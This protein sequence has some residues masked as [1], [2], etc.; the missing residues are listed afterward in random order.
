MSSA[1]AAH[2]RSG[3]ASYS[4]ERRERV[5]VAG[6]HDV[7]ERR[8]VGLQR[9]RERAAVEFAEL[10]RAQIRT[11]AG[12]AAERADLV[13]PVSG[14][15][16]HRPHAELEQ[17]EARLDEAC[18]V[19]QVD[20]DR[21]AA[22]QAETREAARQPADAR[23]Q[24]AIAEPAGAVDDRERIGIALRLCVERI[25]ESRVLPIAGVA[26]AACEVVGQS[27]ASA[28]KAGATEE[29]RIACAD[30]GFRQVVR[31]CK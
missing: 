13:V 26:V 18:A 23:E 17:R 16:E 2:S 10:R 30:L 12:E 1:R 31:K 5:I 4:V 24:V 27:G 20:D 14:E 21:V 9:G 6:H 25:E 22:R 15:G 11:R 19:R 28:G 29:G 3:G 7:L 8:A